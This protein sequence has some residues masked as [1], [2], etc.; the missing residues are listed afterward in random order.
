MREQT[1]DGEWWRP[2]NPDHRVG[3]RIV[4]TPKDG[5]RL[6]LVGRLLDD[7]DRQT[8][9]G[10]LPVILG[11]VSS[12]AFGCD[13]TLLACRWDGDR[14]HGRYQE[15]RFRSDFAL[16]GYTSLHNRLPS[17]PAAK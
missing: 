3:G 14:L 9:R 2:E 17:S 16:L 5:L 10:H 8:Q 6:T 1:Y 11:N 4:F 15:Q 7:L 13:V 12:M